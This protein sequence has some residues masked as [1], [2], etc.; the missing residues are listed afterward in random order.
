MKKFIILLSVF[1]FIF[2]NFIVI[3]AFAEPQ[4]KTLKQG[5]YNVR[6]ANLLVDTPYTIRLSSPNDKAIIIVIDSD[7]TIQALVRLNP[8][9]R[10]Q[11]LP[12][13]NSDSTI[14]IFT[15]GSVIFL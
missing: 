2:F 4:T 11:I 9:V 7:Q 5:F 10:Q 13:F 14:I 8:R 12:S 6:D 1:L 15:S 3:A